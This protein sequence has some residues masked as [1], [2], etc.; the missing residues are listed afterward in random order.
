MR[1]RSLLALP[2]LILSWYLEPGRAVAQP[3]VLS[4]LQVSP[5][6]GHPGDPVFVM[7]AGLPPNSKELLTMACPDAGDAGPNY[8]SIGGP[9]TDAHG[10]FV[11]FNKLHAVTPPN[12]AAPLHCLVYASVGASDFGPDI[13][14]QYIVL[15]PRQ[16]ANTCAINICRIKVVTS[17]VRVRFG[18][19]ERIAIHDAGWPG[20]VASILLHYTGGKQEVRRVR[21]NYQGAAFLRLPIRVRVKP[22][23]KPLKVAVRVRLQLGT[24]RGGGGS[25]FFVVH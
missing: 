21:L 14:G 22:H 5:Y 20:A 25:S 11:G 9:T 23:V 2:I 1:Y 10:R 4:Y 17:P 19:L 15:P 8:V 3:A 7:G 16:R 13:K 6:E 18:V 12:L 24:M